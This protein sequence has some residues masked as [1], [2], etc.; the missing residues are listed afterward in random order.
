MT[1]D[2][3]DLHDFNES[4]AE[5]VVQNARRFANLFSAVI[6]DLL[7]DYKDKER[8]TVPKDALDV[9]IEHRQMMEARMRNPN[10]QRDARNNLPPELVKRL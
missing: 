5:A 9:Y 7:P 6:S 1:I 10:E 2:L 8:V 3:D 4:L